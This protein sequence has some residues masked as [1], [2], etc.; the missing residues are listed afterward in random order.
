MSGDNLAS[1]DE[2]FEVL[3]PGLLVQYKVYTPT[4]EPLGDAIGRI[5]SVAGASGRGCFAKL[6]MIGVSSVYYDW[7]LTAGPAAGGAPSDLHHHFCRCS[8]DVCSAVL[9]PVAE[10]IDRWRLITASTAADLLMTWGRPVDLAQLLRQT[11]KDLD[12]I[13][14]HYFGRAG[15]APVGAAAAAA[16]GVPDGSSGRA[17]AAPVEASAA[18]AGGAPDGSSGGTPT[19]EVAPAG[20]GGLVPKVIRK[21]RRSLGPASGAPPH[22]P[23]TLRDSKAEDEAPAGEDP[24][25]LP[26][27]VPLSSAPRKGAAPKVTPRSRGKAA[28]A[29]GALGTAADDAAG[30]EDGEVQSGVSALDEELRRIDASRPDPDKVTLLQ[31]K[32]AALKRKLGVE[33]SVASSPQAKRK[34]VASE[35]AECASAAAALPAP[36]MDSSSSSSA[37]ARGIAAALVQALGGRLEREDDGFASSFD[38]GADGSGEARVNGLEARRL[39]F[40]KIALEDPG[41][42]TMVGLEQLRSYVEPGIRAASADPLEPCVL[43]YLLGVYLPNNPIE[44]LGEDNFRELRTLAEAIDSGLMGRTAHVLDLLMQRFKAKTMA[45]RDGTWAAARWLELLPADSAPS[46]VSLGELETVRTLQAGELKLAELAS[47]HKQSG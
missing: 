1:D 21:K 47:K 11:T 34:K 33:S 26:P 4:W 28:A 37:G 22:R 46:A 25:P 20:G 35:L 40:K 13:V 16:G 7:W 6:E 12:R 32:L 17:G 5:S 24:P 9:M 15:A 42:L 19:G 23:A 43:R 8:A 39:R 41:R 2:L 45:L 44:R 3:E 30:A 36:P 29:A 31:D 14:G 27:P 10:H 38:V 18:A